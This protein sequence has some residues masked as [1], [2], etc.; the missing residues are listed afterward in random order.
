MTVKPTDGLTEELT[1]QIPEATARRLDELARRRGVS[2]D[3]LILEG[4]ETVLA[5]AL[6]DH[7]MYLTDAQ[8]QE[9]AALLDKPLPAETLARLKRTLSTPYPWEK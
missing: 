8:Y 7:V 9:L 1:V 5:Q 6:D 2:V 3:A 4:I